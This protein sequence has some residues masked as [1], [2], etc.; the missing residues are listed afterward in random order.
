MVFDPSRIF[1]RSEEN[2]VE[3]SRAVS[4]FTPQP[5]HS[6]HKLIYVRP[7]PKTGVPVGH[8]PIPESFWPDQNSPTLVSRKRSV[9]FDFHRFLFQ[10]Y[11]DLVGLHFSIR[12]LCFHLPPS[13]QSVAELSRLVW[14]VVTRE[15]CHVFSQPPR[16]AHPVVRF[17]CVD[18]EPMVIDKLPFDKYELEPSP[19]TQYVLE[20]KSP[21]MCWQVDVF[22][23]TGGSHV[24]HIS[25]LI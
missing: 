1:L 25:S 16:S 8:W 23:P 6:C 15:C 21:H 9:K 17:S 10:L 13:P 2:S 11:V 3:S 20:R 12:T 14:F 19:L 22:S 18:C 7:N 4:S 5:W 24:R